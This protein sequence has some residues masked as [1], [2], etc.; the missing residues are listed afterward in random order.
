VSWLSDDWEHATGDELVTFTA[1]PKSGDAHPACGLAEGEAFRVDPPRNYSELPPALAFVL[2]GQWYGLA[3]GEEGRAAFMEGWAYQRAHASRTGPSPS[4][5]HLGLYRGDQNLRVA[6][7]VG[8]ET[9]RGAHDGEPPGP[10]PTPPPPLAPP[11]P[12]DEA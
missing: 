12:L 3:D 5:K 8:V 2:I 4:A 7:E 11:P 10:R 9:A 1:S 6:W